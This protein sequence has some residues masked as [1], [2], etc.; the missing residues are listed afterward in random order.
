MFKYSILF[1]SIMPLLDILSC[2]IFL[3]LNLESHCI[4]VNLGKLNLKKHLQKGVH[5]LHILCN[6]CIRN[7]IVTII[8]CYF[9]CDWRGKKKTLINDSWLQCLFFYIKKT[10]LQIDIIDGYF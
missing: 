1:I 8:R 3:Q 2:I 7:I 4:A 10:L 5:T 9:Y 6:R